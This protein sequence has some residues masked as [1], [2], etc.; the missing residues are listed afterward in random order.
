M[1]QF[2]AWAR[3]GDAALAQALDTAMA[4]IAAALVGHRCEEAA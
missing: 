4:A 2:V 3:L 1:P